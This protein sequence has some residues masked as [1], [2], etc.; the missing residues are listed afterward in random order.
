MKELKNLIENITKAVVIPHMNPDGDAMGSCLAFNEL[1]TNQ[2]VESVILSPNECPDFLKWMSGQD[3]V[4]I[5]DKENESLSEMILNNADAIFCLDFNDLGRIDRI[6]HFV[7]ASSAKKVMIDHHLEPKD[8][9]DITIS[10]TNICST[11][12][13]VFSLIEELFSTDAITMTMAENLYTG[14]VTDTGSFK[15]RSTDS[16]THRIASEIKKKGVDTETVH[17]KLFDNDREER[18]RLLG[19]LLLNNMTVVREAKTAYFTLSLADMERFNFQKGD[20]EGVVNYALSMEGIETAAFFKESDQEKVKISFRSKGSIP[21]NE[22]SRDHFNGGG[23]RNAAGG[24]FHGNI[25]DAVALFEKE[26]P[27]YV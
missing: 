20:N 15:Y 12:Q 8:F 11:C 7:E 27:K 21:V 16:D 3:Q 26:L 13:I 22:L 17:R 18:L 14:I 9:A 24:I 19:H 23:H 6:G 1:L 25:N 10:Q 5:F 4:M 2:G